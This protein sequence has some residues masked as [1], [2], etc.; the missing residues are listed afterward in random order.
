MSNKQKTAWHW[1][2]LC[3]WV[4][5]ILYIGLVKLLLTSTDFSYLSLLVFMLVKLPVDWE[6]MMLSKL[7]DW[8]CTLAS[9]V[10]LLDSAD[11]QILLHWPRCTLGS[12][13]SWLFVK[14]TS[15]T[16]PLFAL[17]NERFCGTNGPLWFQ[18]LN[19]V[20]VY[21]C[22]SLLLILTSHERWKWFWPKTMENCWN[23]FT[24]SQLEKVIMLSN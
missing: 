14:W 22:R 2:L 21:T 5:N 12:I 8:G 24:I 23:C 20:L 10:N 3:R 4:E 19:S 6:V 7:F 1:L 17:D 9:S 15:T 18:V 16:E 11:S 13:T